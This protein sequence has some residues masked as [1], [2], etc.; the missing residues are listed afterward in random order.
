MKLSRPEE[1]WAKFDSS[2]RRAIRKAQKD[3][4]RVK[5]TSSIYDIKLFYNLNLITKKR[6]GVPG[7]P[8]RMFLEMFKELGP[9]CQL[10]LAEFQNKTIAG[11]VVIKFK[12][13]V[14][15][16]YG[17]SDENYLLHRPNDLLIWTAIEESCQEGYELFDFGRTL[18]TER[19]LSMFKKKWGTE[20]KSLE[21]YYYPHV[22]KSMTLNRQGTKYKFA[23]SIWKKIPLPLARVGSNIIFRYLG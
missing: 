7:H 13:Q 22:P 14:L 18:P 20:E 15:Y 21:Y 8:E 11:I 6:L 2:V 17:A 10:Y 4:V 19:G 9:H 5:K 1:I 16:G 3:G 12:G 23:T